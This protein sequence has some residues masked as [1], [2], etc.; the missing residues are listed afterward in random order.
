MPFIPFLEPDFD[1]EVEVTYKKDK[2]FFR[3]PHKPLQFVVA[4]DDLATAN[5]V[6]HNQIIEMLLDN[7]KGRLNTPQ[8]RLEVEEMILEYICGL[9][10]RGGIEY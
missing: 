7:F 6:I 2:L 10:L 5:M 4:P 3:F 9:K 8:T 1:T